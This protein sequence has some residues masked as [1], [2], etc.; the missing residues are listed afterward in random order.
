M[1]RYFILFLI[2]TLITFRAVEANENVYNESVPVEYAL[3][4]YKLLGARLSFREL[5]SFSPRLEGLSGFARQSVLQQEADI[6]KTLYDKV[7]REDIL[8]IVWPAVFTEYDQSTNMFFTTDITVDTPYL[9]SEFDDEF[10]IFIA[11]VDQYLPLQLRDP[12]AQNLFQE[13]YEKKTKFDI[14]LAVQPLAADPQP[15]AFKGKLRKLLLV[16]LAE[17]KVWHKAAGP[18]NVTDKLV[19]KVRAPWFRPEKSLMDYYQ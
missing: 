16:R 8:T 10:V 3:S 12:E 6:L 18:R 14:E 4:Y 5:A 17:M 1:K 15:F 19:Y 11:D 7:G 13:L 9:V 2:L